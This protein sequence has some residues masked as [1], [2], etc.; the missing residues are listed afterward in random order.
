M[1]LPLFSRG[2][3]ASGGEELARPEIVILV[4][5]T[6]AAEPDPVKPKWWETHSDYTRD[7]RE[8]LGPGY[9]VG[10]T[11]ESEPFKWSGANSERDRRRAGR[12]LLS[13]LQ[14][15]EREGRS[16]HLVGHSHG[17]SVIW[18]MLWQSMGN[19]N[20]LKSWTTVGT[21][22]LEFAPI[23][24]GSTTFISFLVAV[25]FMSY[26]M[27]LTLIAAQERKIVLRDG[28]TAGIVMAVLLCAFLVMLCLGLAYVSIQWLGRRLNLFFQRWLENRAKS[29]YGGRWFALWHPEDEPIAGLNASLISPITFVPRVAG[30]NSRRFWRIVTAPYNRLIAPATDEFVWTLLMGRLQGSDVGGS[31]MIDAATTPRALAPG[32]SEMPLGLI[33]EMSASA[34]QQ[35]SRTVE[36]LRHRLG[37]MRA[38]GRGTEAFGEL[39]SAVSWSEILHTSYFDIPSVREVIAAGIKTTDA[40]TPLATPSP[41]N[42]WL[43][44]RP[45]AVPP[46]WPKPFRPVL[47]SFTKV[48]VFG[49]LA[50][51]LFVGWNAAYVA[52][53]VPHTRDGQ[54]A[55]LGKNATTRELLSGQKIALLGDDLVQLEMLGKLGDPL[56]VLERIGEPVTRVWASHRL[57][58]YYGY[59]GRFDLVEAIANST[60]KLPVYRPKDAEA[61]TYGY[62]LAGA[63]ANNKP[64]SNKRP[65]DAFLD[66]AARRLRIVDPQPA[67]K[68]EVTYI[69]EDGYDSIKWMAIALP[70]LDHFGHQPTKQLVEKRVIDIFTN[71]HLQ[72]ELLP[73]YISS[74]AIN[75][76]DL[77]RLSRLVPAER[78]PKRGINALAFCGQANVSQDALGQGAKN[79]ASPA[80]PTPE[81]VAPAM[82]PDLDVVPPRVGDAQFYKWDHSV[83]RINHFL[84][85]NDC[86][87]A[88]ALLRRHLPVPVGSYRP[89]VANTNMHDL[90]IAFRDRDK[91]SAELIIKY[92]V[93]RSPATFVPTYGTAMTFGKADDRVCLG[94]CGESMLRALAM[95]Y[96]SRARLQ[97]GD[98]TEAKDAGWYADNARWDDEARYYAASAILHSDLGQRREA[99]AMIK[100]AL[101]TVPQM[102]RPD[103]QFRLATVLGMLARALDKH[104]AVEAFQASSE[105]VYS[106]DL[107]GEKS[108]TIS[109]H[110]LL[111]AEQFAILGDYRLAREAA[112]RATMRALTDIDGLGEG[113]AVLAGY[114]SIL[115]QA[116][117]E[118]RINKHYRAVFS[119]SRPPLEP[120]ITEAER[121]Q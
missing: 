110:H 113:T 58:H 115:S 72:E 31:V 5:G 19:L 37:Q 67:E 32:W 81:C 10:E 27:A 56:Q 28:N 114:R 65:S 24:T 60:L 105:L 85:Q 64:T 18:H 30:P 112:E 108:A 7:L 6:G 83:S 78:L 8:C 111:L 107:T 42:I 104:L 26:P 91:A 9:D 97:I 82:V 62:A 69:N 103:E 100:E 20:G 70:A 39:T 89:A 71:D 54:L 102:V 106:A 119:S 14:R 15:L 57:A 92:L 1:G 49:G 13:R 50:A 2:R 76:R 41:H 120:F 23:W 109:R 40:Q 77:Q 33:E 12:R 101:K 74:K 29:R 59:A 61:L 79:T 86:A 48:G 4:H 3:S 47:L 36:A 44:Q 98:R 34:G 45:Q 84:S 117:L 21:P 17:G 11:P 93:A 35:A 52:Y 63:Q 80:P 116:M 66:K 73:G 53:V 87:S 99:T 55:V 22:F 68:E 90:A 43:T 96:A 88:A 25:V 51:L 38:K 118:R 94:F 75:C 121:V 95:E 16:Y 46:A